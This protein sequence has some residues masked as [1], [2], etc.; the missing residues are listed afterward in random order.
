MFA[1]LSLT[2]FVFHSILICFKF[3]DQISLYVPGKFTPTP[4]Q[5]QQM[6]TNTEYFL[7]ILLLWQIGHT[8]H[9]FLIILNRLLT[10]MFYS[11]L[12][13]LLSNE[14]SWKKWISLTRFDP[15]DRREMCRLTKDQLLLLI[16]AITVAYEILVVRSIIIY[17]IVCNI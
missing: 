6:K 8:R 1:H 3:S 15:N 9:D 16:P 2:R 4:N 10:V 14:C 11:N 7:Q 12:H 5:I 13:E 17:I